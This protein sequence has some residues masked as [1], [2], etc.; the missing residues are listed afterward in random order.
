MSGVNLG[1]GAGK[2]LYTREGALWAVPEAGGDEVRLTTLDAGREEVFHTDPIVLPGGQTV[3][4]SCLT[5]TQGGE[6]IE[7]VPASGG[8]RSVVMER[9]SSP[10]WSP[11]GHLLF[12]REGAV[13]VAPFDLTSLA[14]RGTAVP[15]IPANVV[16][17]N[18]VCER[19][20]G[21]QVSDC[22][23]SQHAD[24]I[25][26]ART[27]DRF[28]GGNGHHCIAHPIWSTHQNLHRASPIFL[29]PS[30]SARVL[31]KFSGRSNAIRQQ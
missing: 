21:I 11:T 20:P 30:L 18:S 6:R 28:E 17:E 7:A 29:W 13:W 22:G 5:T 27:V 26:G 4:F 8:R 23:P 12:A 10:V 15:V 25:A 1:W 2:V 14:V 16:A 9:A 24:R 3:L 31:Q 19:L